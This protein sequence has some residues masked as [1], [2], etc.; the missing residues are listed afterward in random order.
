MATVNAIGTPIITLGGTFT[1]SGAFPFV[2]NL[3]GSTNVTFPTSGTL[4]T[5]A[6]ASGIVNPGLINQ[7]GYYASAGSTIS[8]LTGANQSALTTNG[9]GVPAWVPMIAG[10]I[11]VGTT[12]GAPIAAAIN[13]GTN[14]TVANGSGSITVNLSGIVSPTLGGTGINN[15]SNTLTLAGNLATSG[16]FASTFTMTGATSVTFPTSGTLATTSSASGIVNSGL[17]N[18]L[19]WYAASGTTVSGLAT[20]ASGILVTSAGSVPSIST[21]LPNGLAMGIPLSLT[22]T[23]ATGLPLT[24][25]V[26][27]NLPVGNLNSGTSASATTFWRGDGTWATPSNGITPAA[28]TKTDD[29][30]VTLTLAGTPSTALLQATSLTLG[31]TGTLSASRGGTGI[32][33]LGT[34]VATALGQNV[35]GSGGIVLATSPTI[36]TPRIDQI[37]DTNG[38][39]M[40]LLTAVGSAVNY[41]RVINNTT[42][43]PAYLASFGSDT[44]VGLNIQTQGTG[45][46]GIT[47]NA[48][49]NQVAFITGVSGVHNTT[50]NFPGTAAGQTVT[51]PDATGT[52][53]LQGQSLGVAT[54]TSIS[55]GGSALSTYVASGSWTPTDNSGA[56]LVFT[57]PVGK[58]SQIGNIVIASCSL[59]YPATV[60]ASG[61]VIGGLPV[62]TNASAGQQGGQV[63]YTNA[64]T[65]ARASTSAGTSSANLWTASGAGIANSAMTGSLNYFMFI[66]L[67]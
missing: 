45:T 47:A 40:L 44:N 39:T 5:T 43:N 36:T 60:N 7:I 22:L 32:S 42:G 50:M 14:I 63:V 10:Q 30:N 9:S 6:G 58:Y 1:M 23:N 53:Q 28:L 27:G 11:L 55:F 15:G 57:S 12:S 52:V 67:V 31:W 24:T 59:T 34:G 62:P 8:G 41:I 17:I 48:A 46:V 21:T 49:T 35:T 2:G 38:N 4:A 66:Y 16:A 37:N 61:A 25:G 54:A 33:S 13:S 19:A 56:G 3:T 51:W 65:L 18:Q 20:A 64:P 29:T 26:T